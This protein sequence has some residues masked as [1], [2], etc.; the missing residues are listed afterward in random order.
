[1]KKETRQMF[2]ELAFYSS[3]GFT[4]VL[5]TVI[6]LFFGLFIDKTF[7]TGPWFMFIFFG[8]GIAAA[9]RQI[10]HAIKKVKDM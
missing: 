5:C 2:R 7:G 6:G 9:G 3:L 4:I 10:L 1:M 8:L